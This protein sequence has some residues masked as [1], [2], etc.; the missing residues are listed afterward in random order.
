MCAFPLLPAGTYELTIEATGFKTVAQKDIL[1][2]V[3]AVVTMDAK[4]EVG[5]ITETVSVAADVPVVET[6]RS[7]FATTVNERSIIELPVKGRN[8]IDFTV[9]TPG[10]VKD[11]T[12]GGDLAFGGQRGPN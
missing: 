3:G 9:L 1:L 12:R 8:F 6:S 4:L 10:V 11:P 2:T 7:N 5:G